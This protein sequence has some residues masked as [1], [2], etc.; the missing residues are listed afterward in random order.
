MFREVV[1][2]VTVGRV[3]L[4]TFNKMHKLTIVINSVSVVIPALALKCDILVFQRFRCSI[5]ENARSKK[6]KK[7]MLKV[8]EGNYT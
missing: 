1:I 5:P 4:N 6:K 2:G 8:I 7:I 3:R